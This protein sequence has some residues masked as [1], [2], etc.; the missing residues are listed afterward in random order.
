MVK[1]EG[2]ARV[3]T[4]KERERA[5]RR[6]EIIDAAETLF[7]SKG[8]ENTTM[9]EIAENA[10]FGK[11]TLY[12]YFKSKDEILF[13]VHM[14]KHQAKI[15]SFRRAIAQQ[16]TGL[17]KLRA[18]GRAYLEFYKANPEYLRMQVYWDY[19]GRAFD[20]FSDRLHD[21]MLELADSFQ[22]LARILEVGI[23]D[24]SL[25]RDLDRDRTMEIFF[26]TLRIV[27]N[28]VLLV[29]PPS[30]SQIN[31]TSESTYFYYLDLLMDAVRARS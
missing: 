27:L 21:R 6:K 12:S 28:Q 22:E 31:D 10:E 1:K 29:S 16:G 17:E 24:G 23:Q 19:K 26:L 20:E 3:L 9:E 4:R 14:R 8:F 15:A 5:T 11:P 18:L 30:V 25:R 2:E 7:S 13:R